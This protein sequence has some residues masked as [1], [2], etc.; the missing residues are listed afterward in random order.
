MPPLIFEYPKEST[1]TSMAFPDCSFHYFVDDFRVMGPSYPIMARVGEDALLTCQ[2]L[3]KKTVVHMEVRWYRT[4]SS[5]PVLTLL[6]GS[7]VTEEQLE[8]YRGRVEWIED[9]VPEGQVT[10]KIHNI[11]PSDDGQYWCRFQEGN[12]YVEASVNLKVA[13]EC[14][15]EIKRIEI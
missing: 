8:E 11:Q 10:L 13:S 5:T 9:N 7:D 6:E 12:Y 15:L 14:L 2:L 3:P 4:E 1:L